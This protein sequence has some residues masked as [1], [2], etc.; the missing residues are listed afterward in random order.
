M[1]RQEIEEH[2]MKPW[3]WVFSPPAGFTTVEDFPSHIKELVV[4]LQN[5]EEE[6]R[7]QREI[8]RNTCKIKLFGVHPMT[9]KP[10]EARLEVHKDK[11]LSEATEIAHKVSRTCPM[12]DLTKSRPGA[13]IVVFLTSP[14]G[15]ASLHVTCPLE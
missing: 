1:M 3:S 4:R 12:L 6:E 15:W 5:D 14:P 2:L 9:G 10:V 7:R 13:Y 8:D 11:T